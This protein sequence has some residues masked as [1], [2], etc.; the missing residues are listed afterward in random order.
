MSILAELFGDV[1]PRLRHLASPREKIVR[2]SEVVILINPDPSYPD[3]TRH[4]RIG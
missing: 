2:V 1:T 3:F 4:E